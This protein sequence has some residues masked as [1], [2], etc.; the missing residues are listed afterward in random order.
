MTVTECCHVAGFRVSGCQVDVVRIVLQAC[1]PYF[2]I[3]ATCIQVT[4]STNLTV[5]TVRFRVGRTRSKSVELIAGRQ[6]PA[7]T[8]GFG[9]IG[10][11][12]FTLVLRCKV[13]TINQAK[14]VGVTV[15]CHAGGTASH[16]AIG[17][18]PGIATELWQNVSPCADVVSNTV[19]TTV[20][21]RTELIEFQTCKRQTRFVTVRTL[22]FRAVA[23][24]LIFPLAVTG[25]LVVDLRFAF[26]AQTN[27]GFVAVVVCFI[28]EIVQTCHFTV[29]I[30]L[31]TV[32][33]VNFG[34]VN[35]ACCQHGSDCHCN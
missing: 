20:V 13:Q 18:G 2:C 23:L 10:T 33:V 27:V 17:L 16:K 4:C 14:E 26:E 7:V 32:F 35:N 3:F 31:V 5:S 12:V 15:G 28:R 19:V 29:Q 25:H 30:Q 34:S 24:E 11:V 21:E 8:V 6:T 1:S 22:S 9:D